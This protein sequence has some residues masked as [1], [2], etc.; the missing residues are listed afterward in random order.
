MVRE[1]IMEATRKATRAGKLA[2]MVPVMILVVGR[3]VAMM[4]WIPTHVPAVRYGQIGSSTSLTGCHNQVTELI[5]DD[6]DVRHEAVS[7]LRIKLT[8]DELGIVLLD[9]SASGFPQQVVTGV[10]LNTEG[11]KRLHD[12][13]HVGDDGILSV[14]QFR[15][16]C[17]SIGA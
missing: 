13:C 17:F 14:G 9:V 1:S 12:L 3:W 8:G 15:K 5:D 6:D 10:H 7:V 2:L 16:E 4:A 11:V